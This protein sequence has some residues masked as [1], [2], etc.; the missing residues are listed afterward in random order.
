M[1][2]IN[3]KNIFILMCI[4]LPF[5]L[6]LF[7]KINLLI[8]MSGSM[9]KEI[10]TGSVCVITKRVSCENIKAGDIVTFKLGSQNVTH[11]VMEIKDEYCITKG[12]NNENVDSFVLTNDKYVGKY[13]F[14]IPYIGYL[15]IFIKNNILFTAITIAII[16]ICTFKIK[17]IRKEKL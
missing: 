17:S 2:E 8:C 5:L 10:K 6:C 9:E 15:F 4:L 12:D 11:R 13:L 3:K 7:F 1:K 14:S 16:T